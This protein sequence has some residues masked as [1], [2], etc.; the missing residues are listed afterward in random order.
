M[1]NKKLK[2]DVVIYQAKDGAI[3]LKGDFVQENIWA[4]QVQISEIFDIDRS[5]VTRHIGKIFKDK[6]I[7]EKSNVQKMHIANSD[8]LV[9]FYSLDLI[10]SV[11]YRTNSIR[12]IEF[13]K[14][15]NKILK[16]HLIQ[17][18]T[19]NRKQIV[20]NYN[21]FMKTVNSIQNLLPEHIALDPKM[22]LDLIKEFASTWVALDAYDKDK[23]KKIGSSKKSVKLTGK[24][25]TEAIAKLRETLIKKGEASNLFAQEKKEG[26]VEGIIGNV[27]QSFAGNSLYK[28]VEEKAAHLLYFMVKNHPF[29][30]GNKRSGAFAFVWF[31]RKTKVKGSSNINPSALTALTLLIAESHPSKKE[32]MTNLVTTLLN[33]KK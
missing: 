3:E 14:W 17:G 11:G 28:T 13:R 5:V 27:M 26:S 33:M 15:A 29:T 25:L 10:L 4:S 22:V 16:N 30:D 19:I 32:Q 12:A 9:F 2:N 21:S 7:I 23:L 24:E 18:Y 1:K 8:K 20:K 6:E 31:L